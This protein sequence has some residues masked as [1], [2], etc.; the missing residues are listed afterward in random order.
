MQ[1]KSH[2][3][4]GGSTKGCDPGAVSKGTDVWAFTSRFGWV[5]KVPTVSSREKKDLLVG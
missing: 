3:R 1:A 5:R 4:V 2:C